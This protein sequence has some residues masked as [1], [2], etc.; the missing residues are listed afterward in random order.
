MK[1]RYLFFVGLM[2]MTLVSCGK[3]NNSTSPSLDNSTTS[4]TRP[5][6]SNST[7]SATKPSTS[8]GDISIPQVENTIYFNLGKYG[9]FDGKPGTEVASLSLEYG[10]SYTALTGTELPGADRVTS[11]LGYNFLYWVMPS[12]TGGALT[13]VDT[14]P[15]NPNTILEAW[16]E[17]GKIDPNPD[18]IP[19]NKF[20][21]Y[22]TPV[23]GVTWDKYYVYTWNSA[24]E[25]NNAIWP[26]V[27]LTMDST[28]GYYTYEINKTD[29]DKVIFNDGKQNGALQTLDLDYDYENPVFFLTSVTGDGKWGKIG[30]VVD[31]TET[32]QWYIIGSMTNNWNIVSSYGMSDK[33]NGT[34]AITCNFDSTSQFKV[35]DVSKTNWIGGDNLDAAS[36]GLVSVVTNDKNIVM[37]TAGRYTVTWNPSSNVLNIVAA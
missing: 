20:K 3:N 27:A 5:S 12:T 37:N 24:T 4:V 7:S 15:A 30:D 29:F 31:K 34:F 14:M 10:V 23:T 6:T 13:R 9:L 36:K 8:L 17:E 18:P 21:F 19:G 35:V 25:A 2:M 22:F 11:S 26:G 33:G 1:K 28:T 32:F 16:W